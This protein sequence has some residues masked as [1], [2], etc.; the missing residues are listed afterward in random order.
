VTDTAIARAAAQQIAIEE[1]A[2]SVVARGH[3]RRDFLLRRMLAG[4]DLLALAIAVLFAARLASDRGATVGYLFWGALTLPAWLVLFKAY[5]LY[6]RDIKRVS[7]TTVDDLPWVFHAL[8]LGSVLLWSYYAV[9]PVEKLLYYEILGFAVVAMAGVLFFRACV[10]IAARRLLGTERMAFVGSG[11]TTELL[12]RKIR[13]HPEYRLEPVGVIGVPG[14]P[15][16]V[17]ELPVLGELED[18]PE[19]VSRYGVE[20]LV[21]SHDGLYEE[22]LIDLLRRSKQLSLKVSIL[23]QMFDVMGPAV[24]VDD[25]EGVTV[26]GINPPVLSRSSRGLKR[27]V[28]VIGSSL[29]LVIG[30]PIWLLIALAIKI[31]S[32]GPVFFRQQRIGERGRRF[33]VYKFRTMAVDAERRREELL[34]QSKDPHW[35]HLEHDPRITRV[36]R[37]L[38]ENSIDELPQFINVL[39][40]EMSIVGPRPLIESEDAMVQ[41]WGRSRLDLTPGITGAWQVLGR[42]NIPFEEMVKLDYLYVTNW[43]LWS[44]IRL[45]LHT[46]PAVMTRRGAN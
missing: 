5:G 8:L 29:I 12:L 13:S 45:I 34:A 26:L 40:G 6:D 33:R 37:F 9:M 16:L 20:R 32:R 27:A 15:G 43:S 46:L 38:R 3:G 36:G 44:D 28:D 24:E 14:D 21:L 22:R 35:L 10:R 25:V 4:A 1:R 30:M 7:H 31:D 23:P 39:R 19:I 41:G 42:T 18:L 11:S 2:A 17:R